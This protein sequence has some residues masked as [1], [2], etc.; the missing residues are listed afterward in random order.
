MDSLWRCWKPIICKNKEVKSLKES[1]IIFYFDIDDF[2]SV[3]KQIKDMGY[4]I[5]YIDGKKTNT[6]EKLFI[7]MKRI[8]LHYGI[9]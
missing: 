5:Y 8:W 4:K 3:I 9:A 2:E 6:I 1:N 7:W